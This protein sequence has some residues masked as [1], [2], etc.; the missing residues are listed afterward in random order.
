[1]GVKVVRPHLPAKH[2]IIVEVDKLVGKT[3]DPVDVGF[4]GRGRKRG[5]M[6][7]VWEQLLNNGETQN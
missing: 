4:D 3:G 6:T 2:D 5:K 1:M 7:L